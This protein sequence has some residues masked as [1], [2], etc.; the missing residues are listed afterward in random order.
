MKTT[1]RIALALFC[2][3]TLLQSNAQLTVFGGVQQTSALYNIRGVNQA[4]EA[5]QGFIAGV[6]LKTLIEGPAY[7][8]PMLFYSQKGYKVTFDRKA[9]PPD[10]GA[11]NNNT[12]IHTLE[13]APLIQFNFSKKPSY[14]F[15]R[16]G[17]SIDASL[18]G[19]ESFDS[20]NGKHITQKMFFDFGAYGYAAASAVVHLGFQHQSGFTAFAYYQYGLSNFNN[21]DFGPEIFHRIGGIAIGW[22]FGSK[23]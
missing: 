12:T 10:T 13:L 21:A 23:R 7:F 14:V 9:Y 11:K 22:K 18:S 8:S 5:K 17:P 6:G 2:T 20:T 1:L 3:I 19:T 16:I 15:L 4:T